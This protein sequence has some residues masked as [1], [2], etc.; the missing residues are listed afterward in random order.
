ML[1]GRATGYQ[2]DG[3]AFDP[4][5]TAPPDP[6]FVLGPGS[7]GTNSLTEM[8]LKIAPERRACHGSCYKRNGCH[9]SCTIPEHLK[10]FKQSKAHNE[11]F[12]RD[13]A[14]G[15]VFLDSGPMADW[16]WLAE[17]FPKARWVLATRELYP[18]LLSRAPFKC[19]S[20]EARARALGAFAMRKQSERCLE[21]KKSGVPVLPV[22]RYV[23]DIAD[24]Q[25]AVLAHFYGHEYFAVVDLS[26]EGSAATEAALRWVMRPASAAGEALKWPL[27]DSQPEAATGNRSTIVKNAHSHPAREVAFIERAL[28]ACPQETWSDVIYDRCAALLGEPATA[29]V[30]P[31]IADLL[32]HVGN[33]TMALGELR[34]RMSRAAVGF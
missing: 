12:F 5:G 2:R 15:S 13:T 26:G 1:C 11:S 17:L 25:R 4:A 14:V 34:A 29:A 8:I 28:A 18:F 19:W 10:W 6:I 21:D 33:G 3:A 24:H 22:P 27:P 30:G 16:R 7:T 9:P 32:S 20:N 31:E 23:K